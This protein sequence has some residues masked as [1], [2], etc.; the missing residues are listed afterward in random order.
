MSD[1]DLFSLVL[2]DNPDVAFLK[3]ETLFRKEL[4]E[5]D[6]DYS[7][8]YQYMNKVLCAMDELQIKLFS[9]QK[10]PEPD[11]IDDNAFLLFTAEIDRFRTRVIIRNSKQT[12]TYSV[13]LDTATK[14]KVRH[15]LNQ[16]KEI[17]DKVELDDGKK[18]SLYAKINS[19]EKEF[20][21]DRTRLEVFGA[22]VVET[23]GIVGAAAKKMEPARK[24]LESIAKFLG[25]AKSHE[26]V[27]PQLPR[28][29]DPK[30]IEPQRK[31]LPAPKAADK[32]KSS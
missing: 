5:T 11:S 19:L 8:Y 4:E 21:Q 13:R 7:D 16:I 12:K 23:A 1:N 25:A 27:S 32:D 28:H 30:R 9:E 14:Q 22:L 20:N 15:L 18:E 26:G 3:L 2:P 29:S 24:L 31:R 10:L 6:Q 17:V